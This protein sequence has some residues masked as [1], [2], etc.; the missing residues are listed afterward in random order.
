MTIWCTYRKT[1]ISYLNMTIFWCCG[2]FL[3]KRTRTYL[4]KQT[5]HVHFVEPINSLG[6]YLSY[7]WI[8][9]SLKTVS[10]VF[11]YQ[12]V[13]AIEKLKMLFIS[14]KKLFFILKILNFHNSLILS[15]CLCQPLLEK[16]LEI[17]SW[18]VWH[19]KLVKKEFKN[20][21]C[22]ISWEGKYNCFT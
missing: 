10:T 5:W 11:L 22:L 9:Q 1:K 17:K 16:K 4:I 6:L 14:S 15:F 8:M 3:D 18:S 7:N 13:I 19:L 20:T 12:H 2:I 21:F